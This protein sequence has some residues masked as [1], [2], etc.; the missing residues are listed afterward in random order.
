VAR[1]TP[2]SERYLRLLVEA[3]LAGRDGASGPNPRSLHHAA[4]A[5][6]TAGAASAA[7]VAAVTADLDLALELRRPSP[8]P[9]ALVAAVAADVPVPSPPATTPLPPRAVAHGPVRLVTA[10]GALHVDAV[11]FGADGAS[12]VGRLD[13]GPTGRTGRGAARRPATGPFRHPSELHRGRS[14]AARPVQAPRTR[15]WTGLDAGVGDPRTGAGGRPEPPARHQAVVI[16]DDQGRRYS[17]GPGGVGGPGRQVRVVHAVDPVPP[18]DIRWLDCA[19]GDDAPQRLTV[20]AS[21]QVAHGAAHGRSPAVSW[22][23]GAMQDVAGPDDAVGRERLAAGL[24]ALRAVGVVAG[25]DAVGRQA[26]ALTEAG[27]DDAAALRTPAGGRPPAVWP[28]S[29]VVDLGDRSARLDVLGLDD[30]GL[31]LVGCFRP[32]AE[33]DPG[34]HG[35]LLS[36]FDD[37]HTQYRAHCDEPVVGPLGADLTWRL[38][39]T[40]DP[41]ARRLRL[42]VAGPT[43]EAVVEVVVDRD[44]GA[45]TSDPGRGG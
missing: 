14:Q 19:V 15:A 36:A 33:G 24:A 2:D 16:H 34:P 27:P 42:S 25:D 35:W 10:D 3:V 26:A 22:L 38:V 5:L 41:Q 11:T 28:I 18:P 44:D 45:A 40:L 1:S 37:R 30:D 12:L 6:V 20:T 13:A 43:L 21:S 32:W 23:L 8:D 4:D 17:L 31:R 29:T 9:V 7:L 39:P